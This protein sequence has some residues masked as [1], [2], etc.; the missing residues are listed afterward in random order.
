MKTWKSILFSMVLFAFARE[1]YCQF[2]NRTPTPNDNLKST[3]VKEDGSVVFRIY[4]PN[5]NGVT[6][7]GD[8]VPWGQKIEGT[9]AENG[10]WTLTIPEV[11]PGTYRYHF[12]V[13]GVKVY[14]PKAPNA[15]ETSALIDVLP[16]GEEAFFSMKKD[17][18]HGTV[19]T[20]YYFSKSTN[21]MRRMHI[22]TPA[23][24][25]LTQKKL[26]VFYL[27]HGGGDS[28]MAWP[29][30]GR[31]GLIMDNLLA[32]GKAEEM[33][34]VMPDGGIDTK[35]FVQDFFNDLIPYIESNYSVYQNAE[36]RALAGLSMGGLEVLDSFMAHPDMFGYINVMSSG[37]FANNEEMYSSGDRRLSEIASQLNQTAKILLFTL[38]GPEDI[39][40][41]NG[42]EMLKVFD[43]NGIKYEFSEMPGG[44]TWHVWRHDLYNFAPRL[45]K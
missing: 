18:P 31:A 42:N 29:N 43:K 5:S 22:W 32:E 21:S 33:I 35:L 26:P 12:I 17:I 2:P 20:V 11:N 19:S 7:G 25:N 16:E 15:Y 23:A 3:E 27:I 39:A 36:Y 14:D 9:K 40:Y 28:D 8:I 6:L 38:G 41:S 45:F 37:W 24:Y 10:V 30:V 44:H 1:G 13:D 4:A 34:L